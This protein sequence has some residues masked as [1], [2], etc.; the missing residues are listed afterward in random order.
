MKLDSLAFKDNQEIPAKY[1]RD[2]GNFSP[3][4]VISGVPD[5]AQSLVLIVHDP[6]A[7]S[8]DWV[9]WTVWNIDP[10]TREIAENDVPAGATEGITSFGS[11]GYGGPAPPSGTHRYV[12]ELYALDTLLS[13]PPETLREDLVAAMLGHVVAMAKLVGLFTHH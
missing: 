9:H 13:L 11:M 5:G 3:P 2:G 8:G 10:A 12:F 6:D 7:P 1:G 4:L